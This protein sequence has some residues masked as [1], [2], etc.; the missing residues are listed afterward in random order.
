M[1]QAEQQAA[2]SFREIREP[3]VTFTIT[4]FSLASSRALERAGPPNL[5]SPPSAP[6]DA[7]RLARG[8]SAESGRAADRHAP[9]PS[10][11]LRGEH[12]EGLPF[13]WPALLLPSFMVPGK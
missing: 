6:A 4:E 5:Q 7:G 10:N 13:S 2:D 3:E 1:T 11:R 9:F 12:V 8:L